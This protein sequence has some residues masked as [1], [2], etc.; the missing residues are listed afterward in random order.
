M[1]VLPAFGWMPPPGLKL[2]GVEDLPQEVINVMKVTKRVRYFSIF[3]ASKLNEQDYLPTN[4]SHY[5][6]MNV[7]N[8]L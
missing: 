6:R 5:W 2:C 3:L 4:I 8:E 1:N 7:E